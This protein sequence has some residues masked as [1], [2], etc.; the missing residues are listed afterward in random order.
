MSS[1]IQRTGTEDPWPGWGVYRGRTELEDLNASPPELP[2]APPWRR[3]SNG[4]GST[5]STLVTPYGDD[6]RGATYQADRNA[7][8]MVNAALCLRR[9][10]LITG[11]PGAGK[12]TLI[13]SVARE[14]RLGPVLRWNITSRT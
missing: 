13:Y 7:V 12:S 6:N 10:L 3:F 9:P 14:L 1:Q 8:E 5:S 11:K 2:E 4:S